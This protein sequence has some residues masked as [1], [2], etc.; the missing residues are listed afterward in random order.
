MP[1]MYYETKKLN[2]TSFPWL[3]TNHHTEEHFKKTRRE[4]ENSKPKCIV[5]D[6]GSVKKFN[7]NQDNLVD[8]YIRENYIPTQ[9]FADLQIFERK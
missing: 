2:P 5:L 7:Y 3:I 8:E 4:L 6:Y 9:V 1:G